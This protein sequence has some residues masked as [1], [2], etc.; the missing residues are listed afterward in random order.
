[1]TPH[2]PVP[3]EFEPEN[4]SA[5]SAPEARMYHDEVTS[6]EPM[7]SVLA[8]NPE[9][10]FVPPKRSA[11]WGQ[12]EFKPGSYYDTTTGAKHPAWKDVD[13]PIPTRDIDRLRMDFVEWGY[14]K[15]DGAVA[16]DQIDIIRERVLE[17]AKGERL[18][19]IAQKTQSGQNINCCVNK[20]LC[21]EA[22]IEQDPSVMQGGPL[23]EQLV[24]EALGP[25]W[26]CTSLIAAI[27]VRGG[28]PQALHQDQGISPGSRH[29]LAVNL[30]T[31]ITDIDEQTGGT[32]LIPGSHRSLAEAARSGEP[33]GRLPPAINLDAAA[34]TTVMFDG[35]ILHGTGINHTDSPRII[36]LNAMQVGWLRQQENWMLSVRPEVLERASEKLLHRMGYQAATHGQTNEG[37]GFGAEGRVGEAAG[38]L[39]D[40]RLAA[41]R[42]E[43]VRVGE[44]GSDSTPEQTQ[45]RFTL[46]D[47]V[48]KARAGGKSAP[49]GIAGIDESGPG[50]VSASPK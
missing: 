4:V 2:Q 29:P 44:L 27:A 6:R 38:A 11:E 23:L 32:L 37:H 13:L 18:A 49:L 41:D 1:M 46:R 17:Q 40:F 42:N 14:C 3:Q 48:A 25:G 33:V 28:V 35:R 36:M 47:V 26:I 22:L 30:L 34:G 15:V 50:P 31:P 19:G 8:S 39:V 12:W 5:R 24:D 21:F 45:A 43:Y 7:A 9:I 20:G 10:Y 16:P